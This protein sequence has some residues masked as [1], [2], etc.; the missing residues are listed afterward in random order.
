MTGD[1]HE[2]SRSKKRRAQVGGTTAGFYFA[3][4]GPT[5]PGITRVAE[6]GYG[7]AVIAQQT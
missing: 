6:Q 2:A 7:A 1:P 3:R 4:V 5:V